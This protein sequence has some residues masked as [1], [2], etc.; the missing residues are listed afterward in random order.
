[1]SCVASWAYDIGDVVPVLEGI[2][3]LPDAWLTK[4]AHDSWWPGHRERAT[5][6]RASKTWEKMPLA[7]CQTHRP[8]R[9]SSVGARCRTGKRKSRRL[10]LTPTILPIYAERRRV[11]DGARTRDLL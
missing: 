7:A 2:G 11:T 6:S 4:L 9:I 8:K 3:S 5:C 10:L 1:V